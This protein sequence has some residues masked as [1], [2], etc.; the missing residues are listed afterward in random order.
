MMLS[1][2]TSHPF[3]FA[4]F[5]LHSTFLPCQFTKNL[6]DL[7]NHF[8]NDQE[9]YFIAK[10]SITWYVESRNTN[11]NRIVQAPTDLWRVGGKC[12]G[13]VV[14]GLAIEGRS[15]MEIVFHWSWPD[16]V[17]RKH[18]QV[19]LVPLSWCLL[20]AAVLDRFNLHEVVCYYNWLR[21]VDAAQ[22]KSYLASPL[23][24]K[25]N[26][27]MQGRKTRSPQKKCESCVAYKKFVCMH[28][29]A[30]KRCKMEMLDRYLIPTYQPVLETYVV[31]ARLK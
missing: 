31:D 7:A 5:V 1:R 18:W 25:R 22:T 24:S 11:P 12:Q 6:S 14:M 13:F 2:W 8:K 4:F 23:V 9:D 10:N 21:L 19:P 3:T 16:T 17:S 30:S 20:F 15:I 28:W 29:T 26:L 27:Y